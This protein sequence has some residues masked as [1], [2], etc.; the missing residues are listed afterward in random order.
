MF[1]STLEPLL[2]EA[3][4]AISLAQVGK[5]DECRVKLDRIR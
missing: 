2:L 3:K 1:I 5:L 4:Q